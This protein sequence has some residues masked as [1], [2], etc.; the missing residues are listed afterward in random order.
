MF[1]KFSA[2]MTMSAQPVANLMEISARTLGLISKQQTLLFTGLINDSVK[3]VENLIDQ[4]ELKGMLAA[5][6][7][8]AE[9]MRERITGASK[10]TYTELMKEGSTT[11]N[12]P[13]TVTASKVATASS[14]KKANNKNIAKTTTDSKAAA[15]KAL[16][17]APVATSVSLDKSAALTKTKPATETNKEVTSNAPEASAGIAKVASQLAKTDTKVTPADVKAS[18]EK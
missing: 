12:S 2:Q 16:A 6:S 11:F 5:Q 3:L 8:F 9:S 1:D 7:V 17:K 15:K 13:Q 10:A 4:T 14:P 18:I